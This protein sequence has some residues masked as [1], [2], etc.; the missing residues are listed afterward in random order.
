MEA[1]LETWWPV[2]LLLLGLGGEWITRRLR[3]I[4]IEKRLDAVEEDLGDA[5]TG[6]KFRTVRLETRCSNFHNRGE[7]KT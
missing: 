3:I 7:K 5:T 1:W 4:N 2:V 6:L